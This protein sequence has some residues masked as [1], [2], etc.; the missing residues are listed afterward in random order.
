MKVTITIPGTR[1]ITPNDVTSVGRRAGYNVAR[2]RVL[3]G[4]SKP[5]LVVEYDE[6]NES[7]PTRR[8]LAEVAAAQGVQIDRR[9]IAVVPRWA[10]SQLISS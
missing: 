3:N 5:Q 9:D 10:A 8:R 7:K 1:Y 4:G 6:A 2:A